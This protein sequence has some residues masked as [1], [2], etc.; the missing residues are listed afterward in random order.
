MS[1]ARLRVFAG[2]NGSGKSTLFEEFSKKYDS[3]VFLNAYFIEKE[4]ATKGYLDLNDYNL[5]ISN[6]DLVI[7]LKS[8]R[9]KS[10]I[11]RA[12]NDKQEID[13]DLK[14]N[15]IY[16]KKKFTHSYEGAFKFF[17]EAS[18]VRKTY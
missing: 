4:L 11:E 10:L 15:L 3:G 14:D 17:F 1:K 8:D 9:A 5:N 2:P 18:F 13:F 12:K 16:D 6:E 7:F